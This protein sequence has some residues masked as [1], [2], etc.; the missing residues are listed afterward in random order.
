M[1]IQTATAHYPTSTGADVPCYVAHPEGDGPFPGVVVIQEWW[2]LND[3]I[4]DV[5]E[6]LARQGYYAVAPDLY[7]GHTAAEP[8]QARK[9]AMEMD[10]DRAIADIQ[11]AIDH[12]RARQDV[13][14]HVVGVVGFC[15]GG[16][17][18]G[19]MS[20]RG[21]GV[22]AVVVFYGGGFFLDEQQ[23][24]QVNAPILAI[25]GEEDRS[26]PL[27]RVKETEEALNAANQINEFHIFP[28]VGHAFFNDA[29]ESSYDEEAAQKAWELTLEWFETYLR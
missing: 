15:M 9:L 11:G 13:K 28:G 3:H 17:L 24:F 22:G 12:L 20:I 26:I 16:G 8:D 4:K 23:A 7:R 19:W 29:R 2:G 10:R 1:A 25:Y 18:A 5:T 27:D 14:P 6:R 21:M